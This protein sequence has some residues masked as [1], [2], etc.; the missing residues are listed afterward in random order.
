MAAVR[1]SDMG[2]TLVNTTTLNSKDIGKVDTLLH[3][4]YNLHGVLYRRKSKCTFI[5][6][7]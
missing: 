5:N 4:R 6:Q 7:L 2:Q 3:T 1:I